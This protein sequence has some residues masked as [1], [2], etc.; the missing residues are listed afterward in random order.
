MISTPY[1]VD[2]PKQLNAPSH[3]ETDAPLRVPTIIAHVC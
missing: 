3:G 1:Q 2:H